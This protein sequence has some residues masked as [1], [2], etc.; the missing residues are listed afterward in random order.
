MRACVVLG[1]FTLARVG[2][3]YAIGRDLA[4]AVLALGLGVTQ[5]GVA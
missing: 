2:R 3:R 5:R 4:E 1:G